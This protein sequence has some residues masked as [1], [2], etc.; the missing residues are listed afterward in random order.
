MTKITEI[1]ENNRAVSH[2][3]DLFQFVMTKITV[4]P[5]ILICWLVLVI[6]TNIKAAFVLNIQS[7]LVIVLYLVALYGLIGLL[8]KK[9]K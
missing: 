4:C 2:N 8:S 3:H 1:I 7:I 5:I 9:L 6:V